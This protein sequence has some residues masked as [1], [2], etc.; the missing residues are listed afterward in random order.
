MLAAP[1]FHH[2][3]L[4]SVDPERAIAGD[5]VLQELGADGPPAA[6][7]G[8]VVGDVREPVGRAVGHQDDRG[9]RHAAT[10]ASVR[11]WTR[12]ASRVS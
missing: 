7:V 8:V 4:N 11:S 10:V 5:E 1:G 6:D 12:C 2:L 3:H 9:A